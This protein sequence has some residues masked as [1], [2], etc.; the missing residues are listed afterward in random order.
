MDSSTCN[1]VDRPVGVSD[2]RQFAGDAGDPCGQADSPRR[3]PGD[4]VPA[5]GM[6]QQEGEAGSAEQQR[7]VGRER[8]HL[9]GNVG[10]FQD[11]DG[12]VPVDGEE[13]AFAVVMAAASGGWVGGVQCQPGTVHGGICTG[14]ESARPLGSRSGTGCARG[15][16]AVALDGAPGVGNR[17]ALRAVRVG[18][19]DEQRQAAG[20]QGGK[21]RDSDDFPSE[22]RVHAE[23][24][25]EDG[26]VEQK[27]GTGPRVSRNAW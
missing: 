26:T 13:F 2:A 6:G 20:E 27:K 16:G 5:Q 19:E 25:A 15:G 8:A 10:T 22:M 14:Q 24:G 12:Q 9:A 1:V 7:G 3:E 23:I 21:G 18:D 17:T 11:A 4:R